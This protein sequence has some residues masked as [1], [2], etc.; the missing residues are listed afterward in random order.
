MQL[1]DE[2]VAWVVLRVGWRGDDAVVALALALAT[3]GGNTG[4]GAGTAAEP[5]SHHRGLW[6]IDLDRYPGVRKFDLADPMVSGVVAIQL[7]HATDHRWDWSQ[8]WTGQGYVEF[9][10]RARAAVAVPSR[11]APIG[12]LPPV[13]SAR[14]AAATAHNLITNLFEQRTLIGDPRPIDFP[15]HQL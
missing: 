15:P 11:T 7:W 14:E 12:D 4:Y 6:G 8:A 13:N 9:L 3:S 2:Q 5:A 1:T 10:G